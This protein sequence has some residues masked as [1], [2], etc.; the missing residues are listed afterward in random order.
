M[1][2][3]AIGYVRVSTVGQADHEG[4]DVQRAAIEAWCADRG[5]RIV[6]VVTDAGVSGTIEAADREGLGQALDSIRKGEA[7]VLVAYRVD[8]FAR[9]VVVQEALLRALRD[10]GARAESTS[11][12]E[13]ANLTDDQADPSRAMIRVILAAVAQ[14]ERAMIRLRMTAGLA[15]KARRGGYTGGA[16]SFG[17][18]AVGGELEPDPAEAAV[19]ERI[20]A[21]RA[22]GASLRSIAAELNTEGLA[23]KRGGRWYASSVAR[24]LERSAIAGD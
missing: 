12:A 9:D 3:S 24:V 8:R 4:P 21:M 1:T 19:A 17:L 13:N 18:V 2:E 14:Y 15:A 7:T 20:T 11:D 16:P 23:A 6:D 10:M 22:D 5:Y